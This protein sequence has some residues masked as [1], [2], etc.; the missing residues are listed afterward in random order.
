ME[1]RFERELPCEAN[2]DELRSRLLQWA[3]ANGFAVATDLRSSWTF[4]RGSQLNALVTFDIRKIPTEATVQLDTAAKVV[5]ASMVA[6]A[7]LSITTVE[8]SKRMEAEV[9]ALVASIKGTPIPPPPSVATNAPSAPSP[10]SIGVPLPKKS[11]A[12]LGIVG[13]VV[14]IVL[15]GGVVV[16]LVALAAPQ[17]LRVRGVQT[18]VNVTIR[19]GFLTA[20]VLRVQNLS[21]SHLPN[22]VVSANRPSTGEN[23]A[24]RIE[25]LAPGEVFE[26][27]GLEWNW[28]VHDG[29][30]VTVKADGYLPM[31]FTSNQMAGR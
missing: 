30:T 20:N 8:D 17:V 12:K 1:M 3:S 5:R 18:P 28:V 29:D 24:R 6:K 14:A 2:P 22:V 19:E 15:L 25:S 16:G 11:G 26:L 4:T 23:D 21:Q 7:P 31:V 10:A 13:A 9:E 27:G